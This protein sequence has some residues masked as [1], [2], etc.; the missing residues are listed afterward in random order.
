MRLIV[1][2]LSSIALV[3]GSLLSVTVPVASPAFAGSVS[4][5]ECEA[6]GGTYVKNGADAT[7]VY[8]ETKPGYNPPGD[9]GSESQ[10]TST[11]HGNLDNK[12]VT[13]CEGNPGQCKQ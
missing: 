4:Q 6:N 12:T 2:G 1:P 10:D 5:R 3:A 8:P 11:G 7:C 13:T 9:Q